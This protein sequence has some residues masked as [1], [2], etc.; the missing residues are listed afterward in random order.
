VDISRELQIHQVELDMQNGELQR[1]QS[2]LDESLDRYWSLFDGAPFGYLTLDREGRILEANPAAIELLRVER[3]VLAGQLLSAFMEA[4]EVKRLDRCCQEVLA[5]G[6]RRSC[7]LGL[8]RDDGSPCHV[9]VDM[10]FEASE[11]GERLNTVIVDLSDLRQAQQE[12][13]E[14]QERFRQIAERVEDA[15]YVRGADGR[16]TY[17]SPAFERIWGRPA[18]WLI[19][20]NSA[21]METIEPEDRDRVAAAWK[22]MA[23]GSPIR[24]E[25]RIR[26]PDGSVRW[27]QSRSVAATDSGGEIHGSVGVI[28]DISSER[29]LEDQLRFYERSREHLLDLDAME[30][31]QRVSTRFLREDDPQGLLEE[32]LDAAIAIMEA[33]SGN[34]QIVDSKSSDLTITAHRGLPSWWVAYWN[35]VSRG[36]G[37]CGTALERRERVIVEDVSQ[38]S[39]FVG[40][41]ALDVQLRAGIQAVQSTPLFGRTGSPLGMIST[42]FK[43][44]R[45]PSERALRLLDLL[46]RQAADLLERSAHEAELRRS[47]AKATNILAT[48]AD[49]IISIDGDRRITEWNARAE[50]IFGYSRAEALGLPLEMLLPEQ[51]R[52]AHREHIAHFASNQESGRP[53]DHRATV[54]VRKSG[55]EFPI[56]GTISSFRLDQ[57]VVMTIV[58]RDITEEKRFEWEQRFLAE[59]GTVLAMSLDYD[60]TL[61]NVARL[62]ARELA[63]YC[64]VDSVDSDGTIRRLDV[65][66]HDPA[67]ES[68]G[69]ALKRGPPKGKPA[70]LFTAVFDRKE[71]ILIREVTPEILSAW[72]QDDQELRTLRAVAPISVIAVPLVARDRL[73]GVMKLFSSTPSRRYER[74]DL[75]LAEEVARRAAL[76]ID[77]ARLYES[78]TRAI[79][80]RDNVLGTV[81]HD[82]RNPLGAI[83]MN[84]RLLLQRAAKATPEY[85]R[86]LESIERAASRM[87]RLIQDLL[88]ITRLEAGHL[89]IDARGVSTSQV[90]AEAVESHASLAASKSC[91]LRAELAP[92]LPDVWADRDRLLQIFEN[93]IG[94]ALKFTGPG[95]QVT[96]GAR[97]RDGEVM[98][99]VD[100]T[101]HGM[102]PEEL[103]HVFRRFWQARS[104]DARGAGLGLPIV[105]GLVELHGG[106]IWAES[107]LG[108]GSTFFFSLPAAHHATEHQDESAPEPS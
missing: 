8:R 73:L 32:I 48:A 53:M 68:T 17:V 79:G 97:P 81:A 10:A 27:V 65:A 31:L 38:S 20:R 49:A 107:T 34:I 6:A 78:A 87:N 37:A 96:I 21:W 47:Q 69:D 75:R 108:H 13:R 54:G 45:H 66:C 93:L 19:E 90:V 36:H 62:T 7:E 85:C 71:S 64:I 23:G 94:N 105:K 14:S 89:S 55:V 18:T 3:N 51:Y 24:E 95:G 59:V 58:L 39:I 91:V 30:R 88:V 15:L 1:T 33:D 43:Q 4:V 35:R 99:W 25:Y 22:R 26:R 106:R 29:E 74:A 101:G 41:E 40:K 70:E 77:N 67:S 80:E 50:A 61:A 103:S 84:V 2:E 11:E 92:G 52:A 72:A 60:Q 86:P 102:S 42:H 83:T 46:A 76:Y 57:E 98:F 12:L 63:D 9:R 82:L 16:V 100:D 5:S 56:S 44:P 28:R 104:A